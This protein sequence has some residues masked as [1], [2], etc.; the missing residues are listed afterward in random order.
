MQLEIE[1]LRQQG[2]SEEEAREA[3]L[4]AFGNVALAQERFYESGRWLWWDRL[5]QDI[6]FGLRMMRGNLAF[7]AVIILT[8]AIG[9]GANTAIF[10]VIHA[11]LLRPLPFPDADRLVFVSE[12]FADIPEM[13]FS[14]AD[15]ADRRAMNT[16]F[17]GSE[18]LDPTA[19]T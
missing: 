19:S 13:Y 14:M 5:A 18:R 10:S 12:G 17:T 4:R 6:R 8:L 7:S 9:I 16:V 1:E 15:L 3:A 2:A 11:V